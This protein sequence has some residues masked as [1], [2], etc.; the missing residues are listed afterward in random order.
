MK[1]TDIQKILKRLPPENA[2]YAVR[3]ITLLTCS[4]FGDTHF[5]SFK[6]IFNIGFSIIF[7]FV[8]QDGNVVFHRS[9]SEYDVLSK[10]MGDVFIKNPT[11]AKKTADMLIKMSDEINAFVKKNKKIEDLVRRWAYFKQL[12][13]D[14][15]AY[16][17]AVFWPSEY[18][19]NKNASGTNKKKIDAIVKILDHAYKYNEKVIPNVD[20]YFNKLGVGHLVFDEINEEVLR[21]MKNKPSK[22]SVFFLD[23]KMHVLPFNEANV[24]N[25]AIM[26][27][28]E[29]YLLSLSK[30]LK[31]IKGLGVSGGVVKGKARIVKDLSRLK[32]ARKGDVLVV[33][34]TRPQYNSF[35]K[36]VKAI[37]T[38]EGGLLCHA[39]MLAREFKIPCVV[40]T[41]YA[42]SLLKSGNVV[43]VDAN[44]GIVKIIKK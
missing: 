25:K 43:E 3:D 34:Q 18:L 26:K 42:T 20:S 8:R 23:K 33:T 4:I 35:I 39:S 37:V 40:G 31:E 6:K 15:F 17:Q 44:K 7:W 2:K 1:K 38:D 29:K 19:T 13:M 5:I 28:Y 9:G 16:H 24:V 36:N 22:R 21:N 32:E 12:Y 11:R 10:K 30:K 41:K 14:F 27:E